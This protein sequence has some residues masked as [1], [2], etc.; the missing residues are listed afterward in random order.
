M[1]Y[2]IYLHFLEIVRRIHI[3]LMAITDSWTLRILKS[4]S[5]RLIKLREFNKMDHFK[6]NMPPYNTF[7]KRKEENN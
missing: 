7:C 1:H 5:D 3:K 4:V 2:T 6:Q